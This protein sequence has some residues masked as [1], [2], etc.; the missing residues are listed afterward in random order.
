MLRK[1]HIKDTLIAEE[2]PDEIALRPQRAVRQKLSW[3]DT[4]K[5]MVASREDWSQ[6]DATISDGLQ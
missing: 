5:A 2:R 4:A 6:W 1:Y 3:A